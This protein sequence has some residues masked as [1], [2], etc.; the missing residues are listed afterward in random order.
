MDSIYIFTTFYHNEFDYLPSWIDSIHSHFLPNQSKIFVFFSD[1]T[2]DLHEFIRCHQFP[3]KY[4]FIVFPASLQSK[5]FDTLYIPFHFTKFIQYFS[6]QKKEEIETFQESH[7]FYIPSDIHFLS[8]FEHSFSSQDSLYSFFDSSSVNI[9]CT[10]PFF[11]GKIKTFLSYIQQYIPKY[12]QYQLQDS[13]DDSFF[14]STFHSYF[15]QKPHLFQFFHIPHYIPISRP[16]SIPSRYLYI[17][18]YGG[19]GNVLFQI[20][21]GISMALQYNYTPVVLYNPEHKKE[22]DAPTYRD[23]VCRYQLL[24]PIYRISKKEIQ[25]MSTY[26][27][28]KPQYEENIHTWMN[29]HT[30]ENQICIDGYFQTTPYFES[31]WESICKHFFFSVRDIAKIILSSFYQSFSFQPSPIG[32]HIRGGDYLKHKDYHLN[33]PQTYYQQCIEKTYSI[34]NSIYIYFTDDIHYTQSLQLLDSTNVYFIQEI[35]KQHIPMEYSY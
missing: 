33:L 23:S 7:F 18:T 27:E 8:S 15:L 10:I 21:T 22:Y 31:Q 30:Q 1:K 3:S 32:I 16:S 4:D 35:V 14:S 5:P 34:E 13:F 26:K 17:K 12:H 9:Q 29:E 2:K 25:P 19:F 20:C 6:L 28:T 11:G 24:N